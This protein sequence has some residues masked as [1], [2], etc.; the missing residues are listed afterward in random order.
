MIRR[1]CDERQE[2]QPHTN[3]KRVLADH[4]LKF[5][6]KCLAQSRGQEYELIDRPDE[7]RRDTAAPDYLVRE[8]GSGR[9]VAIERTQLIEEDFQAAKAR[10]VKRGASFIMTGLTQIDPYETAALLLLAIVRKTERGQLHGIE[11]DER[12][13][14]IRNRR[15]ATAQTFLRTHIRFS[16]ADR[17]DVDHAYLIASSQLLE[18]W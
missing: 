17:G 10:L 1:V 14:L 9:L 5:L 3:D 4:D 11:A 16:E 18:L 6:L 12:I 2:P 7:V 13:L 8:K 15:L